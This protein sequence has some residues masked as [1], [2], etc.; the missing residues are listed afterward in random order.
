MLYIPI[1]IIPY[2]T[3]NEIEEVTNTENKETILEFQ[4]CGRLP[5]ARLRRG[6]NYNLRFDIVFMSHI[7]EVPM[8]HKRIFHYK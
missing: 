7:E 8:E 5:N 4:P 3:D 6:E 2:Y 1:L